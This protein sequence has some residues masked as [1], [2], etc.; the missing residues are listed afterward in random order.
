MQATI[1][2]LEGKEVEK[3]DLDDAIFGVTPNHA[4]IQQA[5]LRPQA[6][7]R[8][9]HMIRRLAPMYAAAAKSHGARR[10]QAAPARVPPGLP[11]GGTEVWC[12]ALTLARTSRICLARCAVWLFAAC[13]PANWPTASL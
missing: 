4:V 10:A 1:Y 9:V 13:S 7:A 6:T 2:N 11:S 5:V 8:Q 3:I 12:S